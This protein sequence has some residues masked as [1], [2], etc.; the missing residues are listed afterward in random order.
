[1]D[2]GVSTGE[3]W[4]NLAANLG[5]AAIGLLPGGKV[6]SIGAKIAKWGSKLAQFAAWVG[7]PQASKAIIDFVRKGNSIGYNN[8]SKEDWTNLIRAA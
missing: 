2:D 3:M 6:G 5:L 7:V 8:L 1:M 4:G